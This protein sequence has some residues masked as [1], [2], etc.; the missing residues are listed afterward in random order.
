M[1]KDDLLKYIQVFVQDLE[2]KG[3]FRAEWLKEALFKVPRHL[4]IEQYYEMQGVKRVILV[5]ANHPTDEQ[6]KVI[7]SDRGL[8]IREL[9]NHSA[10]SQ[11]SLVLGML[12]DLKVEAG[13]KV[14]E[15]GTGS[16]WN[17][18]ILAFG[19][20]DDRLVYSIDIQ[21][22]LIESARAHLRAAGFTRVNLVA[23]DGGYGWAEEAPFDRIIITVGS[24]DI[25]PSWCEQLASGGIL[26]V[27]LKTGGIGDPVLRLQRHNGRLEGEFTQWSGFQTLQG[28]F[29]SGSEDLL[30]P[31]WD[32]LID[33]LLSQVPKKFTLPEPMDINCLFFLRLKGERFQALLDYERKIGWHPTIFNYETESI[34]VTSREALIQVYGDVAAAER[35]VLG[36]KEWIA[37][38]RPRF[39]DYSVE[40]VDVDFSSSRANEWID[41]RPYTT[42]KLSLEK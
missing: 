32:S 33:K 16:G 20:G 36:L 35:L 38:G 9:P 2:Q 7:Y 31:P 25:P 12:E 41:K 19:I 6:L 10:A 34:F 37:L 17:A 40:I 14:L 24:P 30:E 29:W 27:P 18:G 8:M 13:K 28:N 23:G 22:D 1:N 26:L 3:C 11:P 4:F 39:T 5:D 21:P 42:L 15:I